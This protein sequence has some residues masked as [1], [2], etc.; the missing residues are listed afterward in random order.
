MFPGALAAELLD[1]P[2]HG[3]LTG[4]WADPRSTVRVASAT[5]L[6]ELHLKD[7][8]SCATLT[9][10]DGAAQE[11]TGYASSEGMM[12]RL[13]HQSIEEKTAWENSCNFC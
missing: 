3:R 7:A 6:F 12:I 10:Q 9:L 4:Q 5:A 11:R 2:A 8:N 1:F 13:R